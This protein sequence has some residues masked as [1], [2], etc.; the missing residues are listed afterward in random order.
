MKVTKYYQILI[1][2]ELIFKNSSTV[3]NSNNNYGNT[4]FRG[5]KTK[6]IM[7]T[8]KIIIVACDR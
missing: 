6:T 2:N 3:I 7:E 1:K 8:D 5:T 4:Q